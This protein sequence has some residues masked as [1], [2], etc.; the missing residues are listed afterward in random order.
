MSFG[1]S[2]AELQWAM[3]GAILMVVFAPS[4]L[5][6]AY[7]TLMMGIAANTFAVFALC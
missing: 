3:F 7:G 5:L 2:V 4:S 1:S 6:K